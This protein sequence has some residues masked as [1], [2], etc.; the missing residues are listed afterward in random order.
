VSSANI[1][2]ALATAYPNSSEKDWKR[3]SKTKVP[4]GTERTFENAVLGVTVVT[5]EDASGNVTINGAGATVAAPSAAK[6]TVPVSTPPLSVEKPKKATGIAAI[7]T[8][9]V[10]NSKWRFTRDV[11]IKM[12]VESP[13]YKNH[14]AARPDG[15]NADL[16][17]KWLA[18]LDRLRE[19]GE[20]QIHVVVGKVFAG[21]EFTVAGKISAPMTYGSDH[22]NSDGLMAPLNITPE[23]IELYSSGIKFG[24]PL[25]G[26]HGGHEL[27]L[28]Q[29]AD[30]IEP[31]EIPKTLV[32]V[33]RDAATGELF[34][35]WKTENV[36]YYTDPQG[37]VHS[38]PRVTDE[39]KMVT[40]LSSA[41]KYAT[42][43]ACK[44]S[45]REFTGYNSGLDTSVDSGEYYIMG[46]DK[47]MDLPS[48]WEMVVFDKVTGEEVETIDVQNWFKSC[49]RLRVLTTTFGSAVR[50]VY[51]KAEGKGAAA[52]IVFQHRSRGVDMNGKSWDEAARFE[53]Y[54][55]G[56]ESLAAIN[57]AVAKATGKTF[58]E[59]SPSSVAMAGS[60]A[61][62]FMARM[63]L[64]PNASVEV[65]I[66][67]FNTLEEVVETQG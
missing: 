4:G 60:L 9:M 56:P 33:L 61:D 32:Y 17:R 36:P 24:H 16:Y 42:S 52:I 11:E 13:A 18:E 49:K 66:L 48:T 21:A 41:K 15:R 47:K 5:V 7:R 3:R 28:N 39:P 19:S 57:A 34:G 27:P 1:K 37:K 50:G 62:C 64:P 6:S 8:Q 55:N 29:I 40:K 30:A 12:W 53:D 44:A 43:A 10:L 46:G 63:A 31:L 51:K 58:R 38:S 20:S 14:V 2:T 26:Y 59:K 23:K 65:K 22:K 54:R 67:D 35:G 25:V 45:I